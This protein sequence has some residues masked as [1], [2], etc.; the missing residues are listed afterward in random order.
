MKKIK[1]VFASDSFKGSL[2][3]EKINEILT[4][5]ANGV[6]DDCEIV[7]LLVAD[8]G[9]GTLDAIIKTKKGNI[10][11]KTVLDPLFRKV[12]SRYGAFGDS[13]VISM[14]ECSGLPMLS[15]SERNPLKTTTFGLGELIKDAI[16]NGYKK[17]YVTLGGS[18]TNDGGLGALTALGYKFIKKDG[19]V[20]KGV[21]EELGDIMAID[22]ANAVSFDGIDFT[23][24]CDVTNTLLGEKGAS[25]VFAPQK[26]ADQQAVEFLEAGMTNWCTVMNDYFNTDANAIVGGGAAG[27]LGASL[28][29]FLKAKIQSGIRTV[30][31]LIDFDKAIDGATAVITGEGRIDSQSADGKVISGISRRAK[32]KDV[33][34]VAIVGSVGDGYEKCFDSGVTAVYSIID[35]PASL[36]E[37]LSDSENLYQKTALSVFRTLKG[38]IE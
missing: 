8:G 14:N 3:G 18:A 13:A 25:R 31:D 29:L 21:G 12:S 11:R 36:F 5:C 20:A 26:G 2:S 22:D 27:G 6:F 7:P 9:E 15:D 28:T 19:T 23:I 1:L 32:A 38:F 33:P 10:L 24:L 30:L 16:N 34:V 17:I 4:L 37:V 35:K